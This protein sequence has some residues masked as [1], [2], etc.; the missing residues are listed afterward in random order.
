MPGFVVSFRY[1][2]SKR[3]KSKAEIANQIVCATDSSG[4]KLSSEPSTNNVSALRSAIYRAIRTLQSTTSIQNHPT[5]V[6][7]YPD[8][9][10]SIPKTTLTF[11]EGPLRRDD[12]LSGLAWLTA[13]FAI[14]AMIEEDAKNWDDLTW[15]R[16]AIVHVLSK[17][18]PPGQK[19]G[20]SELQK[21]IAK[22]IC[23]SVRSHGKTV[24]IQSK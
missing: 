24:P 19:S 10:L 7:D 20:Q 15:N 8:N 18:T 11:L 21:Y 22:D 2:A 9:D 12:D 13:D 5:N 16:E 6:E 4:N 1:A 23:F 3:L 14:Q 17:D